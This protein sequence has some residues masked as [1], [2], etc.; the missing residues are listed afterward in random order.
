VGCVSRW[1]RAADNRTRLSH[2]GLA[3]LGNRPTPMILGYLDSGV[4]D[5][6]Y[7]GGGCLYRCAMRSQ[8]RLPRSN[9]GRDA[10][11]QTKPKA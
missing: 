9:S 1:C 5:D 3:L 6:G 2:A 8:A 11:V 4:K 10:A 7:K